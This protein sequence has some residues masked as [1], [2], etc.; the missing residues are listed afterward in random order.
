MLC[1][2]KLS[3]LIQARQ[4]RKMNG[5][6]DDT[7][8][9]GSTRV[10]FS[11]LSDYLPIYHM[12]SADPSDSPDQEMAEESE[13]YIISDYELPPTLRPHTDT[14]RKPFGFI[15][16]EIENI[17]E[18]D[19]E[20]QFMDQLKTTPHLAPPKYIPHI[21][22][23]AGMMGPH[24]TG[25]TMDIDNYALSA[26]PQLEQLNRYNYINSFS[27]IEPAPYDI[28]DSQNTKMYH[29]GIGR[30]G[31]AEIFRDDD[32][33]RQIQEDITPADN[34]FVPR[35]DW[36]IRR[37]LDSMD[38][39]YDNNITNRDDYV[40]VFVHG[41][42]EFKNTRSYTEEPINEYI[43]AGTH[44]SIRSDKSTSSHRLK[45]LPEDPGY[46]S[47]YETNTPDSDERYFSMQHN[48]GGKNASDTANYGH[49]Y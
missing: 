41:N 18:N 49:W 26:N 31:Y 3:D 19:Y 12:K 21:R 33:L 1:D 20:A 42:S 30:G 47:Q 5:L 24:Q 35:G 23:D 38:P 7:P 34:V 11:H 15:G 27:D 8:Y 6:N 28:L 22:P 16:E 32:S 45:Y 13:S 10:D 4:Y 14:I 43:S 25:G 46:I 9:L 40:S 36:Q 39:Y 29:G 37:K 48:L 44:D 2:S 17:E